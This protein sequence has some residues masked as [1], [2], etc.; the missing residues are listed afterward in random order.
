MV[1][2]SSEVYKEDGPVLIHTPRSIKIGESTRIMK[3]ITS[4]SSDD[5]KINR[6][7][8]VYKHTSKVR[9]EN[10]SRL[11]SS[12]SEDLGGDDE[13]KMGGVAMSSITIRTGKT[14]ETAF[15]SA[16]SGGSFISKH[17]VIDR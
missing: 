5:S 6:P 13:K 8:K 10:N 9:L 15:K 14:N 16:A 7:F 3:D 11:D 1:R 4:D 17:S 2:T 12:G